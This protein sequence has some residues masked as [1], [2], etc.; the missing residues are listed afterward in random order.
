MALVAAYGTVLKRTIASVLTAVAQV[1]SLSLSGCANITYP[2]NT[3]DAGVGI[4]H[5]PTGQSEGGSLT[6]GLFYDPALAGHQAETTAIGTPASC[7]YNVVFPDSGACVMAFT[8]A[9]SG[10][11]IEADPST[12]LGATI[13]HKLD[14]IPVWTP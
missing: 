7:V 11:D 14:G 4:P 2:A 13:T 5:K 8:S 3:L 6:F 12:G 9:G 10:V 1:K